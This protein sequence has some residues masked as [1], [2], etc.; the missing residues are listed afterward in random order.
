MRDS[1][2]TNAGRSLHTLGFSYKFND[3]LAT[4]E[5]EMTHQ[6]LAGVQKWEEEL[7]TDTA[8]FAERAKL[9]AKIFPVLEGYRPGQDRTRVDEVLRDIASNME[10]VRRFYGG[11]APKGFAPAPIVGRPCPDR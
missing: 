1:S 11:V 8:N 10:G 3:K 6:Q 2:D 5:F 9:I 7:A 4:G